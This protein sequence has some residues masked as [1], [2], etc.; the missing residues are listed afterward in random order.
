MNIDKVLRGESVEYWTELEAPLIYA[1]GEG[2]HDPATYTGILDR[3]S[4]K[5]GD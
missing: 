1:G 4:A 5:F 2:V 3:V